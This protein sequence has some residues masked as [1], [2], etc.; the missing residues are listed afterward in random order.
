MHWVGES[1]VMKK[2]VGALLIL[3]AAMAGPASRPAL[4]QVAPESPVHIAFNGIFF[5]CPQLI[6]DGSAPPAAELA[7]FGFETST[8]GDEG[9]LELKGKDP[10][11]LTLLHFET[12]TKHCTHNYA[13]P[14][15]EQIAGF[16]RDMVIEHG[17]T[18][19]AGGEESGRK[20]DVFEGAVP[21]TGRTARITI[22]ENSEQPSAS[23]RYTEK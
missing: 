9:R 12:G 7:K 8:G 1:S 22:V 3:G 21:G 4:A 13:G 15:Y 23:I 14:G 18:R 6:R 17:F 20:G 19:L 5:L 11:G 10:R 16:A 2:R